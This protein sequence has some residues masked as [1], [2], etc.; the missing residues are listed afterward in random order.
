MV[1]Y[2]PEALARAA[3]V[4]QSVY[5]VLRELGIRISG[6]SHA[7]ISRRL[8]QFG[9]DTSHFTGR[10]HNRGKRDSYRLTPDQVLVRRP[11]DARRVPGPA[12]S[13]ARCNSAASHTS[14]QRAAWATA[15]RAD[16]SSCTS[17]TSTATS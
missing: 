16:R 7:H 3:A 9:I 8:K 12:V 6:G 17:T 15:G 1:E 13:A 5:G 14:A 2:T 4:S 10:A 11:P